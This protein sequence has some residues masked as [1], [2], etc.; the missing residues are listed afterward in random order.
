MKFTNPTRAL[1][2]L[3]IT[4]IL[5]LAGALASTACQKPGT[6][7][8]AASASASA[9]ASSASGIAGPCGEWADQLCEKAGKESTT[10]QSITAT[11]KLMSNASC[12]A[13]KKDIQHSLT[14]LGDQR[15]VC[16]ELV[17][18]LCAALGKETKT[19]EMVTTQTKTFP[20]ERCQMLTQ[21]YDKVLE[22]LKREEAK[23]APLKPE[24]V[25]K[26]AGSDAPS[27]GPADAKVT[28]VEFSDFECPYC[29]RAAET[30]KK[31][32]EKYDGKIRVVFRQFPLSFHKNAD[33]AAQASLA[34]HEQGKFW[35][36]HYKLFEN[37]RALTR[38]DLD[39]YAKELKLD[40]A[41]FKKALDEGTYAQQVKTDTKIGEEV[42][43]QGTPSLFL[44]GK[45]VENPS[46]EA[47]AAQIDE[48][49]KG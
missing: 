43:V 19:C 6:S 31:I 5:G 17:T 25:A 29:S 48:A 10:C 40:V 49:L 8:A 33:L 36:F 44:N 15:K 39:K 3:G 35:E 9:S 18:K 34:A 41:K 4:L 30:T 27:F 21:N 37:Q 26:M 2:T 23:N 22:E 1:T 32:K 20:P 12:T 47:V 24:V 16:E 38:E 45:R 28:L 7:G 14:A 11:A 13:A 46:F 42:G